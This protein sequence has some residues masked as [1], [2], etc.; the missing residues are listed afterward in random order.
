MK[1]KSSQILDVGFKPKEIGH[2]E[3][4]CFESSKNNDVSNDG[5][6]QPYLHYR[7][8][9]THFTIGLSNPQSKI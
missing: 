2:L 9:Q 5:P 6:G 7:E 3:G 8:I 4:A 1:S